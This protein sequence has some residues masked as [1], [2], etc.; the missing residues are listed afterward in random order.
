MKLTFYGGAKTVTGANYLL[1]SGDTKILID[2][3]L[4]QGSHYSEDLNFEPFPYNPKKIDAVCVSH[5]HIDHIGR[6]PQLVKQGFFGVIYSTPP[7]KD[8]AEALLLDAEHLLLEE[9]EKRDLPPLYRAPDVVKTMGLWQ[10]RSYHEKFFVGPFEIEFYDAGHVLG[11][12]FIL[13]RAEGKS[14][15]FSGDLGNTHTP[16]IKTTEIIKEK[17]DYM[18]IESTYGARTHE[19]LEE[20]KSELERIIEDTIKKESVLLIPAFALERTQEMIFELNELVETK[21]ISSVPVFIDSPLAIKLTAVYQKYSH[22][23]M[24][25]NHKMIGKINEG[26]DIF[27]FPGLHMTLTPEESKNISKTPPPKI[28]IAGAGMSQGGRI[29]YY[30][31]EYLEDPNNTV[32]FVG[33]QA[34][35]SLGRMIIDGASHVTIYGNVVRVRAHRE[36]ISGYSAHADQPQLMRWVSS[37]KH[38]PKKIFIVQGEE[39]ESRALSLKIEKELSVSTNIPSFG[40]SVVL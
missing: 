27:N 36:S 4:H 39:E 15:V 1:G 14:I 31:K 33:F 17:I 21:K 40:D 29:L 23:P 6:I 35:D 16:F 28:I 37:M 3:G 10:K 20:R 25:F 7:T 34:K 9:A 19:K 22:D 30:E 5:A 11:S 18:L 2:C 13:V 32:L 12:S 8:V 24:Y 38:L 26:D